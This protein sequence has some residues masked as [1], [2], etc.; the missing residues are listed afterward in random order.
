MYE[1][2][3][4]LTLKEQR[5]PDGE[6]GEDFPYNKV[7]VV[8]PSPI[9]HA[10]AAAEWEGPTAAG[11]IITPLTNFGSTLDE[12]LGKLQAL[13]DVTYVPET[14]VDVEPKVKVIR[15]TSGS[16][17]PTPE[18]VFKTEAPG[19]PPEEGQIRRRTP[20][21]SPL[22]DPRPAANASPLD[23]PLHPEQTVRD[24]GERVVTPVE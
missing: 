15:S 20:M 2:N 16:A 18:E 11:V 3:T 17:G 12:P 24:T 5:P 21:Q 9:S 19:E 13:Y 22:D 10:G 6:T 4:E 8:G 7:R 1:P 23:A 14:E